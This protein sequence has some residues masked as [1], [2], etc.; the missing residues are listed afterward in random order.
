MIYKL[1]KKNFCKGIGKQI[2][3]IADGEPKTESSHP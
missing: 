3:F 1:S 2:E